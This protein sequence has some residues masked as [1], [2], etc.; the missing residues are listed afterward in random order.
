MSAS[1][2]VASAQFVYGG[3]EMSVS[4]PQAHARWRSLGDRVRER[5]LLR[6]MRRLGPLQ[7]E[8]VAL[9]GTTITLEVRRPRPVGV[10]P[11]APL[12][13]WADIWPSGVVL[14]GAVTREPDCLR[15]RR[16]L[17]LGP[18]VGLTAVAALRAGA[19]LV[20][21]DSAPGA[22]ALTALNARA[23]VGREPRRLRV[24]WRSPTR[25]LATAAGA[26][27]ALV[28]AADVLYRRVDVP[29]LLRLVERVVA[30]G[31]ELWL[32]HPGRPSAERFVD[33]LARRGWSGASEGCLS[34]WPDPQDGMLGVVTVH[35]LR[36]PGR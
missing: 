19:E 5:L 13:Y 16:V 17:E 14:A 27:F 9:P 22:L 12:P 32:A 4:L 25:A 26:G 21:A 23:Q 20:V 6:A 2:A 34:P 33:E 1:G 18:G 7:A 15:G 29:P 10:A 31:G 8:R 36:R 11:A 30:P 28:L 24:N 35:R 3:P